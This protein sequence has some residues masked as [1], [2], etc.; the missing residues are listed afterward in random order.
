GLGCAGS[1]KLLAA[2]LGHRTDRGGVRAG[3]GRL[4][5]GRGVPARRVAHLDGRAGSVDL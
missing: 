1:Q 2:R 5:A 4:G 3:P